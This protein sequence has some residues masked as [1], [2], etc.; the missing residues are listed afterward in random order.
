MIDYQLFSILF[1]KFFQRFIDYI[2]KLKNILIFKD[3]NIFFLIYLNRKNL[4]SCVVV[5]IG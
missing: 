2:G 5:N 4:I 1:K 3:E